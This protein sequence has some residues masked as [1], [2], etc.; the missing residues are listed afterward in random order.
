[1]TKTNEVLNE[2]MENAVEMMADSGS[3][4]DFAIGAFIG[5]VAVA[6]IPLIKKG[7]NKVKSIFVKKPNETAEENV[8]VT[9]DD[10]E[11]E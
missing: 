4:K 11:V 9:T 8:V 7:F 2:T 5:G 3:I 10:V 1:M 6:S